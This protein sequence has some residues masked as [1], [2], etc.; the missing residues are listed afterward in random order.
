MSYRG[1]SGQ[2]AIEYLMTYGWMLLVVAVVGGAI[3]A[4][5]GDQSV[6]SSSGFTG[7]DVN[8]ENFG[9]TSEGRLQIQ[10]RNTASDTVE[11]NSVTIEDGERTTSAIGLSE[12]ISV[13]E[14]GFVE[15]EEFNSTSGS[16]SMD[17]TVNYDAGGL[18]N[19]E[20]S[21]TITGSY[22]LVSSVNSVETFDY[23]QTEL[24]NQFQGDL[25]GFEISSDR[26]YAGSKSL[27]RTSFGNAQ[28]IDTSRSSP[29]VGDTFRY[30]QYVGEGGAWGSL[31]FGINDSQ[32]YYR[33][34]MRPDEDRIRVVKHE[35]GVENTLAEFNNLDLER[36]KWYTHEVTWKEDSI[37]LGVFDNSEEIVTI[38][39]DTNGS[40]NSF[41]GLGFRVGASPVYMDY[42]RI[43]D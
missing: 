12:T 34:F 42:V 18:S 40:Y 10:L 23:T 15:V 4:V 28:I 33:A 3:F 7:A 20:A 24:E 27:S 37:T 14:S 43:L 17:V 22:E 5:T 11:I 19:L 13:A 38:Q 8:I 30:Q 16:N 25:S 29:Q 31:L 36:G 41:Q 35:E 9:L 21:G 6:E 2:S 1:L 32:N 39:G 26:A